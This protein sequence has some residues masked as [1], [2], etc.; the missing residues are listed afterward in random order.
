MKLPSLGQSLPR[1]QI[2][3]ANDPSAHLFQS[4]PRMGH[5]NDRS[6]NRHSSSDANVF[7]VL[8]FDIWRLATA[9]RPNV[10]NE[11][12]KAGDICL[13]YSEGSVCDRNR[14]LRM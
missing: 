14:L 12:A 4:H 3:H 2:V 10:H 7:R 6:T 8:L 5:Q 11:C 13:F 1:L 9:N